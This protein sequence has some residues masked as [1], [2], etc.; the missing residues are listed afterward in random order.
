MNIR[1]G[2]ATQ[3]RT[4]SYLSNIII[5]H[6]PQYIKEY[7]CETRRTKDGFRLCNT[8]GFFRNDLEFQDTFPNLHKHLLFVLVDINGE[9]NHVINK[10][11]NIYKGREKFKK[12]TKEF[13][14]KKRAFHWDYPFDDPFTGNLHCF[15]FDMEQYGVP[16][17]DWSRALDKFDEGKYSEIFT[18]KELSGLKGI[19]KTSNLWKTLIGDTSNREILKQRIKNQ[20][21]TILKDT[22]LE[23]HTELDI[24]PI[25]RFEVLHWEKFNTKKIF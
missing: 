8:R 3:N 13:R 22:D 4:R 25:P 23:K 1:K 16:V 20:F 15:V 11:V 7:I 18:K 9:Y 17:K 21:G 10:Y 14:S 6:S 5:S 12:F 19:S 2:E 24:K